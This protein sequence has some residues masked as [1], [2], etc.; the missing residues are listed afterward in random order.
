MRDT[1]GSSKLY[2]AEADSD[3]VFLGE[4]LVFSNSR[5]LVGG[6]EVAAT[7]EARFLRFTLLPDDDSWHHSKKSYLLVSL[8]SNLTQSKNN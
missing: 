3:D 1:R 4:V 2:D 6:T 8:Q 7:S 5:D